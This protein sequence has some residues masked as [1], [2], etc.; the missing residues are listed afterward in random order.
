[1]SS[2]D[3]KK[4][5]QRTVLRPLPGGAGAPPSP[6]PPGGDPNMRPAPMPGGGGQRPPSAPQRTVIGSMPPAGGAPGGGGGGGFGGPDLD[7]GGAGGGYPAPGGQGG[8]GQPPQGGYGQPPGG[9]GQPPGGGGYGQPPGGYG[10]PSGGGGYGQPQGGYGQPPGGYGGAGGNPFDAFAPAAAPSSGGHWLGAT[11]GNDDSF[12]PEQ[13]RPEPI[14]RAPT[15]KISLEDAL[16][17]RA[18]GHSAEVNPIT[19]AAAGLLILFG[20]LR[21]QIVDMQAVPLMTYVTEEITAFEQRVLQAG[22]DPQDAMVAKYALCGTAD[23]IVQ[24][25][26]G[27]DRDVWIQYSMV[28]RFFNRRTSGVGFFQEVEKALTDP[29]RKYHLLELMLT[30]LQLGFEGQYRGMPGGDVELQRVRRRIYETLRRV[31]ARGD[32]DIS[33]HWRGVEMVARRSRGGLPV[34][35]AACMAGAVLAGAYFGMRSFV[36]QAGDAVANNMIAVNPR[37]AVTLRQIAAVVAPPPEPYKPPVL[38]PPPDQGP[39]Q[40]DR[41]RTALASDISAKALTI[42]TAGDY[43]SLTVNNLVLFDSGKADTRPQFAEIAKHIAEALDKEPGT[44][45]IVG[46]TDN[47]PLAGSGRYKNNFD[48]SVA[49]AKAVAKVITPSLTKPDRVQIEGKGQDEPIADNGT[50]EGRA[51]NRRVEILLQRADTLPP[52]QTAGQA[53]AQPAAGN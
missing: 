41:L 28:A 15:H 46:H 22:I 14:Q 10:Q 7:R 5:P 4:P 19:A 36:A 27:T 42:D 44:I 39:T 13:R 29:A 12:F 25:L 8:Y 43:I 16:R 20:R 53:A 23:D 26:P 1:M 51:L 40:I 52:D 45:K 48:L 31:K 37:E 3:P 11:G 34:W 2:D 9:Y 17:V 47:V 18:A 21:S 49:R 30:C 35:V 6:P 32:D 33:P 50:A 24:N 38:P